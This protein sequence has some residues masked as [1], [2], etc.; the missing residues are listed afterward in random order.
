MHSLKPSMP[1][2]ALFLL[3]E[4][5]IPSEVFDDIVLKGYVMAGGAICMELLTKQGWRPS[6]SMEAV[7]MQIGATLVQVRYSIQSPHFLV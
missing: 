4:T 2:R 5:P 3:F 7:I 6:Y 1:T